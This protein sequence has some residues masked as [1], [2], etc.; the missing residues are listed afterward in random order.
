MDH[1]GKTTEDFIREYGKNYIYANADHCVICGEV[2]PE[3]TM[4]CLNCK[5]T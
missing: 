4:V 1:Y 3:G 2:I 5:E